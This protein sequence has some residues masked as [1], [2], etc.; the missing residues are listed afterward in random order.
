MSADTTYFEDR[1][2]YNAELLQN[3][4]VEQAA[5]DYMAALK[6]LKKNRNQERG[7]ITKQECE[8]FFRSKWY[9][10][11]TKI[12]GEWL[13]KELQKAVGYVEPKSNVQQ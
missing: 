10:Q 8:R 1:P 9:E 12:P 2:M 4:I 13:I 5:H 6:C 7:S 3:A 11:L